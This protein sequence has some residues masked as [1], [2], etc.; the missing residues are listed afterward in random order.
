MYAVIFRAE[1]NQLDQHYAEMAAR[2]R[3]LAIAEYGCSDFVAVTEGRQEIALS[4]WDNL[5]QI[6]A[7]KN[8]A[9]H[10]IAQQF[11]KEKGYKHYQV[12]V[13]KVLR[14]YA[15]KDLTPGW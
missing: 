10:Q 2:L 13:V 3:D 6:A 7:W 8:N 1:I 5:E 12:Q 4:Y 9:E 11:G 14:E 15:S